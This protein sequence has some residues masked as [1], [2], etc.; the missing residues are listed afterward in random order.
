[1]LSLV[2]SRGRGSP[3][4][5]HACRHLSQT[6]QESG[7]RGWQISLIENHLLRETSAP[8]CLCQPKRV[9][10]LGCSGPWPLPC[11]ISLTLRLWTFAEF[12]LLTLPCVIHSLPGIQRGP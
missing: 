9:T 11:I 3:G 5:A 8:D 10:P 1:M 12:W 2:L 6:C 4:S 7:G